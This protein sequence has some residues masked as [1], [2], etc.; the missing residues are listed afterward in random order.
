MKRNFLILP[1]FLL[2]AGCMD[3]SGGNDAGTLTQEIRG[4]TMYEFRSGKTEWSVTAKRAVLSDA[5][6]TAQLFSPEVQISKKNK[7]TARIKADK[8]I[9]DIENK[10]VTLLE[11]VDGVSE[12]E[13]V[14]IKTERL[15]FDVNRD[16]IWTDQPITLTQSGV[17][18]KGRGFSAKPDLSE[19]E[20][21]K[22][23]TSLP[24]NA[25]PAKLART[26]GK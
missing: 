16:L 20:I 17:K 15:D 10:T 8:G 3:T 12:T 7:L 6:A 18:V 19:I 2:A 9:V 1:L 23:E 22:Q 5:N 24:K 25:D 4:L 26:H 11:D 13:K 14:T 21:R